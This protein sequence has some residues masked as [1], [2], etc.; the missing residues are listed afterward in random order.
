MTTR[1]VERCQWGVKIHRELSSSVLCKKRVCLSARAV[2]GRSKAV[3]EPGGADRSAKL[4]VPW[5]S[6]R[7]LEPRLVE[8]C[9][10]SDAFVGDGA[11]VVGRAHD[12]FHRW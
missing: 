4:A 7:S 1:L 3:G 6:R 10:E 9:Q 5:M 12:D 2:S 8:C 11:K